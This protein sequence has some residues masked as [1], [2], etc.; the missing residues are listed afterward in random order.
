MRVI[1]V[2]DEIASLKMIKEMLIRLTVIEECEIFT[3]A[4]DSLAYIK[5]HKVDMAFLDIE[6]PNINGIDLAKLIHLQNE[7]TKIIFVTAFD[8]FALDAYKVDAIGYLLKPYTE[9]ELWKEVNKARN[10][11]TVDDT[12][13]I[14]IRTFGT[15]DIFFDGKVIAF[16]WPKTKE[17]LAI[18]VDKQGGYVTTKE[19]IEILFKDQEVTDSVKSYYRQLR[20]NIKEV[21]T[22]YGINN[23]IILTKNG[24]A[25]DSSRVYCDFYELLKG[26]EKEIKKFKG[27]YMPNYPWAQETINIINDKINE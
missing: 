5:D 24:C 7:A 13:R 10:L 11:M 27:K 6:M 22:S 20:V 26:N 8:T 1:C 17:L 16:S 18:L 4:Y 2:D 14:E 12:K 21:L 23:L 9:R 19:I 25:I 15:F 3:N